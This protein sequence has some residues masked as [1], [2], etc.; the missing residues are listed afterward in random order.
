MQVLLS[1][2]ENYGELVTETLDA[3]SL[4]DDIERLGLKYHGGTAGARLSG[5][6]RQKVAIARALMKQPDLLV[7]DQATTVL[8]QA[9]E[10]A[11]VK[12][13]KAHMAGRGLLWILDRIELADNFDHLIVMDRGRVATHLFNTY[14]HYF[15]H[16]EG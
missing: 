5:A 6:Q 11:L 15:W 3:L 2:A 14:A 12:N 8:D 9:E 13:I 10:N 4:E 1:L 7:M 16:F